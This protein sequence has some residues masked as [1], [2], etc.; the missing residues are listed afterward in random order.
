M[1]KL[2]TMFVVVALVMTI[3]VVNAQESPWFDM[4]KCEFCKSLSTDPELLPNLGWEHYNIANGVVTI[5]TVPPKLNESYE[6]VRAHMMAVSEKAMSGEKL[7][8]CGMCNAMGGLMMKGVAHEEVKTQHGYL[9]FM[10]SDNVELQK[11]IHAWSDRT[12]E[13]LKKMEAKM[14]EEDH[15][16]HGHN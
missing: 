11:E 15:S 7:D 8:M 14:M 10:T 1:K 3:S 13:E 6:V 16:G 12:N 9:G 2:L 5:T 4:E